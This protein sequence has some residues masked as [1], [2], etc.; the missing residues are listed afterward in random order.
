MIDRS[1]HRSVAALAAA[2]LVSLSMCLYARTQGPSLGLRLD[3]GAVVSM[4]S[5]AC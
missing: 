1:R 2:S 5:K 3:V 4:F